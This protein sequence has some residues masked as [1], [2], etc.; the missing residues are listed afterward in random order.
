MVIL[1]GNKKKSVLH[2]PIAKCI[3][4]I[5]LLMFK[6]TYVLYR[7]GITGPPVKDVE[8]D[9]KLDEGIIWIKML[10]NSVK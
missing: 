2:L 7:N 5:M 8:K 10:E 3:L 6:E 1:V 4:L 9:K